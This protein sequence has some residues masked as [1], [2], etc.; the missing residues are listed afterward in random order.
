[1][2][3]RRSA[4][5][6]DR[7]AREL[8]GLLAAL[9]GRE[10]CYYVEHVEIEDGTV[11]AVFVPGEVRYATHAV[12]KGPRGYVLTHVGRYGREAQQESCRICLCRTELVP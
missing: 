12:H 8:E 3:G 7:T 6:D 11:E 1:M 4:I 5:L 2:N 10:A 9:R